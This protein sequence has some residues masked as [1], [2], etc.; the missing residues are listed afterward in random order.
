MAEPEPAVHSPAARPVGAPFL[1]ACLGLPTDFTPVWIM[2]Q[3]GRYLPEYRA[4]RERHDFWTAC[5]T[6][7]LACELTLQ[8]IRRLGVDAAILFSDILVPLP[9]M[10]IPV[11]FAPSPKLATPVRSLADVERLRVPV[12][13][14][15]T[16]FVLDAIRMLR[17]ELPPAIPLIGFAAAPWTMATYLVEGGGSKSFAEVKGML[18]GA[19][20]AAAKLLGVCT[21]TIAALGCA[22]VRAGAQ[23]FMLFD[24]WAGSLA[25]VDFAAVAAPAV[26]QVLD[27]VA[28]AAAEL[29]CD[30][31]CIYYAG[32]GAGWL[33]QCRGLGAHVVG[34]DWRLELAEARRRLGPG[35]AVQGNLD[36]SVLLGPP[37]LLRARAS[38]VLAAGGGRGH[39]FNLGHGILPQT[40]PDHAKALVDHVH[41]QGAGSA[42]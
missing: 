36:P 26:R 29:D 18:F 16:G 34:V 2:R 13:E 28:Q 23:A 41:E 1:R 27:A 21:A 30:V 17:A 19:P 9:G 37:E 31:P 10:G 32:D 33:E 8:P 7:E 35:L 5:T 40:P 24:T 22:Q 12:P 25:P 6:P 42:P 14:E 11:T 38:A 39:V 3:A 4:L 15:S 20:E